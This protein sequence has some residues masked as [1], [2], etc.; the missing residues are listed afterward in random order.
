MN[1]HYGGDGYTIL[2][3]AKSMVYEKNLD[4]DNESFKIG[5]MEKTTSNRVGLRGIDGHYYSMYGIGLAIVEIPFVIT[6]NLLSKIFKSIPSDYILMY[7][8]STTNAFITT[9]ICLLVFLFCKRLKYSDRTSFLVTLSFGLTSM[10]WP[11]SKY[12]MTEPLQAFLLLL[13]IYLLNKFKE[14]NKL[15]QII[16]SGA[17]FGFAIITKPFLII[18]LP[19]M[20]FYIYMILLKS[21]IKNIMIFITTSLAVSSVQGITYYS[22]FGN[23]FGDSRYGNIRFIFSY[24]LQGLYGFIFSSGKSFFLYFPLAI[25]VFFSI[26]KFYSLHRYEALLFL[27]ITVEQLLLLSPIMHGNVGPTWHGAPHWGPR[28]LYIIIPFFAI[29]LGPYIEDIFYHLKKKL[30]FWSLFVAGVLVQLPPV[31]MRIASYS[32]LV[33]KYNLGDVNFT[34]MLSPILGG[35]LLVISYINKVLTG[36]SMIFTYY[37]GTSQDGYM[38]K[39]V[40]FVSYDY[41]DLWFGHIF[42]KF[43]DILIIKLVVIFAILLLILVFTLSTYKIIRLVAKD[44][45]GTN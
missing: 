19:L 9:G 45:V 36:S 4:I 43:N 26:K 25:L 13:S 37:L 12:S 6:G 30:L 11:Y 41:I 24:L 28:Y 39:R 22:T 31:I 21:K 42:T 7:L 10:A 1:G 14:N 44:D 34:P 27:S 15:L 40:T 29:V 5:E 18:I 16:L 8:V 35:W 23:F 33:I 38:V 17:I 3:T 32:E 2:L 20:L